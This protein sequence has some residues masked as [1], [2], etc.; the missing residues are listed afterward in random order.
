E[1]DA[2]SVAKPLPTGRHTR[3]CATPPTSSHALVP[4]ACHCLSVAP[5]PPACWH[6]RRSRCRSESPALERRRIGF[7]SA[8][9]SDSSARSHA[10]G[11]LLLGHW[12]GRP[13]GGRA[14]S[15]LWQR[16]ARRV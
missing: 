15:L 4:S 1:G 3:S 14:L 13:G 7:G 5:R 11:E 8:V 10:L 9:W 2:R 12:L 6:F 16:H